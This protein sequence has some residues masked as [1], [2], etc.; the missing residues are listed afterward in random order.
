MSGLKAPR[1]GYV[2]V[3]LS[4]ASAVPVYFDN[5]AVSHERAALIQEDH[6][7]PFGLRIAGISSRA[8]ASTLNPAV[9][10]QAKGR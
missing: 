9:S 8:L 5:F 2:Y 6:Y 4:N 10:E 1:N 7:Y 3:Y